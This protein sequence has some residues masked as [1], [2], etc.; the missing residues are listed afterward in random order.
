MNAGDQCWFL[1][2]QLLP[3]ILQSG[4]VLFLK[5][6]MFTKCNNCK[7]KAQTS[8]IGI[9]PHSDLSVGMRAPANVL[10]NW[11]FFQFSALRDDCA[12]GCAAGL[13]T[14]DENESRLWFTWFA[15]IV[16]EVVGAT[17]SSWSGLSLIQRTRCT[18]TS[19]STYFGYTERVDI[20]VIG[21]LVVATSVSYTV[22][23]YVIIADECSSCG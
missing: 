18:R 8:S 16:I 15:E 10:N 22:S 1:F 12:F 17:K 13:A 5:I 14:T 23:W 4:G 7:M 6:F 20:N 11:S 21:C 9:G 2:V 19:M 3:T